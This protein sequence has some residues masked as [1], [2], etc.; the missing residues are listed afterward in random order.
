MITSEGLSIDRSGDSLSHHWCLVVD[1]NVAYNLNNT[2][3]SQNKSRKGASTK[4]WTL[5]GSVV[6]LDYKPIRGLLCYVEPADRSC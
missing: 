6:P 1:G 3:K 5:V 4:I 2:R